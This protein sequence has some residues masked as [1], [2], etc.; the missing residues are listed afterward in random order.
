MTGLRL[1]YSYAH[2]DEY[3]RARLDVHLSALRNEGAITEWSDVELYPGESWHESIRYKLTLADIILLLV[4]A[5]FMAS[6]YIWDVELQIAFDRQADG[7]AVVIPI[8]VR[9]VDW[10]HSILARFQA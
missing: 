9:P 5:D 2:E 7:K 1:F 8:I 4:S 10:H 6:Q 3:F